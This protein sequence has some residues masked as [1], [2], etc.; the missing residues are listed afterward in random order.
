MD[1][2]TGEANREDAITVLFALCHPALSQTS[3]IALLLKTLGGFSIVEISRAF[4][5]PEASVAKR[6][7]RARETL[8]TQSRCLNGL[9]CRAF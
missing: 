1:E 6:L 2:S 4:L 7:Y 3:Q 8:K 5:M 9:A